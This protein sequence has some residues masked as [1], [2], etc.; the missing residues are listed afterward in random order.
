MYKV[1]LT[2]CAILVS[3]CALGPDYVP[4]KSTTP[5]AFR[6]A[7]A[8][9]AGP[10][11]ANMPWWELLR[12]EELQKI[13]AIALEENKDLK[14]AVATIEEFQARLFVSRTDFAPQLSA[15][16]NVPA[17]GRKTSFLVPGFAS[18]FNYYLLGNLSWELDI[19][20]RIRRCW[21][22]RRG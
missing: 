20:G 2:A 6:M 9:V 21:L 19:W 13:I 4:P 11:I 16:V 12:D 10:S 8:K 3:A 1:G 7:D 17:F 18:P 14:R 5:D 15:S 22:A